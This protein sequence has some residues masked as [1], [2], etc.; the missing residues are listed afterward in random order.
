MKKLV[1]TIVTTSAA[2]AGLL[3]A[4]VL[5]ANAD[6]TYTV[7]SGDS[8]WAIAQKFNTTINHVET[9]NNIKGHYILPGQKLSIK[10]HH[11]H[12][13]VKLQESGGGLVQPGRSLKLS[14]AASGFTFSNSGMHWIRSPTKGLEWV[15][16]ISPSGGTTYYRDSVKGRFTFSRDNAKSTLYLQ[17]DSLRSEDTA[18]YYSA[19]DSGHGY[20]YFDYW[21]QGTTVTVSSGGGGSG[22]GGSGGGGSDIQMTQSPSSLPASLGDRVTIH[23]QASQDISN[24]LTWYQQKPGKAPKLLIYETNKLADGVPSRFSG[25]GSGRDY[26][27]TISS[28][29]SED[30]GSYYCQHY[31]DYPRTFGPGTK[32]EIK[33]AA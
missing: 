21:G 28:L 29:E 25:S 14:C 16:S 30:V 8:V 32:L 23:C 13:Q 11:H 9:T 2:A 4:G 15:A 20:T 18:T 5:N 19:T 31:Y 24:Y 1:S 22:G 6:S 27:F 3:F 33:R 26:S 10:H 12:H 17:M 7:K